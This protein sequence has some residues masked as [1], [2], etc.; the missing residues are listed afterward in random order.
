MRRAAALGLAALVLAPASA[1]ASTT[2]PKLALTAT[3]AHVAI[4]GSGLA[5]VRVMNPG[6]GSVSVDVARAGFSLD[7]RGRPRIGRRGGLRAATA[8]LAVRPR[9]F[10][11]RPGAS[12]VL[13]VRSRVPRHAEPGDHDALVLLTTRRR[14]HA[15]V[16]LRMRIGVVV[17]VRAPGRVVRRLAL[18]RMHVRRTRRIRVLELVV[19]NR[20]NVTETLERGRIR[21]VLRR[22]RVR[23]RLRNVARELRPR[24]S[25]VV[26]L[27]Y[28]GRLRGRF[29][30]RAWIVGPP[31]THPVERTFWIRL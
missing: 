28:G 25:G 14:R 5:T 19:A 26:Q 4:A 15:A 24:T 29:T 27:R 22:G 20:G 6:R 30:V 17:V 10:V 8:W 7:R 1:G 12:R 3:P 23:A 21:V 13:T 16:A 11:L 9:R 2:R 31:G 18:R